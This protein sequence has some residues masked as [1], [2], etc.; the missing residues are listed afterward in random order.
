MNSSNFRACRDDGDE[1]HPLHVRF[2]TT[3]SG[4]VNENFQVPVHT[5]GGFG[6]ASAALAR[7]LAWLDAQGG[8]HNMFLSTPRLQWYYTQCVVDPVDGMWIEA[9]SN[10]FIEPVEDQLSADQEQ[11][12]A[13]IG[14]HDPDDDGSPNHW[15]VLATPVDWA[16]A[17]ALLTAP[18]VL[19]YGLTELDDLVVEICPHSRSN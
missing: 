9:V 13:D 8:Q 3:G 7:K 1:P 6:A 16:E 12:L 19:V 5:A 10:E 2:S 4:E 18:L 17:A 15:C 14:F 11:M